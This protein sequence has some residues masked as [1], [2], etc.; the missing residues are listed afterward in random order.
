MFK[1]GD[2][3]HDNGAKVVDVVASFEG[4]EG[5]TEERHTFQ[6]AESERYK[7]TGN[8]KLVEK[9]GSDYKR[10]IGEALEAIYNP[11]VPSPFQ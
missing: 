4:A 6:W 7:D 2:C 1:V 3:Y 5:Q 8:G 10:E 11:K 9:D